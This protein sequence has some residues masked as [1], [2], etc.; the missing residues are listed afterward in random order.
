[1][2]VLNS[3]KTNHFAYREKKGAKLNDGYKMYWFFDIHGTILKPNYQAGNTPKEYYPHAEETL[4]LLSTINDI[5][6]I[7]YTCSHPHEIQ[8]YID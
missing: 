8:E 2:S 7:L 6:M 4:Q 1:M 5:T 3:I